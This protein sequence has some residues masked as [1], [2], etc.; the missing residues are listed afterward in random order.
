MQPAGQTEDL[1][2]RGRCWRFG[3]NLG[4]DSDLMPFRFALARETRLELLR[5]YA[6]TGIDPEF[7][8]K[9]RPG[10][11]VVAGRRFA[12]G[13]PH[14]QGLLGLRALELGLVVE[15]IPRGSLRNAI[16]AGLPI[17]PNC[18]GVTEIVA[19]GDEIEVDYATGRFLN[20]STGIARSYLP[21]P[22]P[23]LNIVRL[24]GWRNNFAGRLANVRGNAT[25][26]TT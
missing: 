9:A 10:D 16:N 4:V 1:V 6:M 12:Q 17:L 24:G 19:T 3:D 21:L 14:I 8:K 25:V 26:A 7:P 11:I 5:D 13:N 23:L 20:I 18:P 2:F 15:S 22:P